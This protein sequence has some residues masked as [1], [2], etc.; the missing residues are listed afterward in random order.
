MTLV[1]N[2]VIVTILCVLFVL[3]LLLAF[4]FIL[5]R[6]LLGVRMTDIEMQPLLHSEVYLPLVFRDTSVSR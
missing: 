3:L 6:R 2:I 1:E 4:Y 5:K